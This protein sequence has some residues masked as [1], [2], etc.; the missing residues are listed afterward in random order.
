VVAK[1]VIKRC[2]PANTAGPVQ[3]GIWR[4]N[5]ANNGEEGEEESEMA[6]VAISPSQFRTPARL[7]I[8]PGHTSF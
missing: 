2:R 1:A 8:A 7:V 6:G 4:S 5:V 3:G